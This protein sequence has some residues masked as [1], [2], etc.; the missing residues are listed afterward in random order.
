MSLIKLSYKPKDQLSNTLLNHTLVGRI[1]KKKTNAKQAYYIPGMLDNIPFIRIGS[2]MMLVDNRGTDFSILSTFGEFKAEPYIGELPKG[3]IF[4][5]ARKYW[6][7][8]LDADGIVMLIR[9]KSKNSKKYVL[10]Q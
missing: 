5:T 4:K 2:G 10:K 3:A 9:N 7:D 8:K 1:T 6:F